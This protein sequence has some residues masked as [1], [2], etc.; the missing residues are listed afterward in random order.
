[1][2]ENQIGKLVV[3]EGLDGSGKSV[4]FGLLRDY[5]EAHK[6]PIVTVDFPDYEGSFFGK[7]VGRYLNGEFGDVYQVNPYVSSLLYAGDRL[8]SRD[9]L[10]GWLNEGYWVLANRY[11]GSNMAYHSAKVAPDARPEFI[12][13]LKRLEYDA[14]RLPQPDLTLFLHAPVATSQRMV[15]Q[16]AA[17]SY[18][19]S[20][21]DIHERNQSYLQTVSEQYLWLCEHEPNWL[22]L[23]VTSA[24]GE[25]L[26]RELIQGRILEVLQE[27]E[28]IN[29]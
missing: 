7:L 23:N 6:Y 17:R 8:E 16:K 11:T 26:P 5:L 2:T 15:A 3:L 22:R 12:A 14:N 27:R 20:S 4:Q 28:L 19:G 10:V 29:A 9:K 25:L 24:D 13:W 1:M 18:T 21:H